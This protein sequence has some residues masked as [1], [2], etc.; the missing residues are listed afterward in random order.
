MTVRQDNAVLLSG[1]TNTNDFLRAC[2]E[3]ITDE[4]QTVKAVSANFSGIPL[5]TSSH[6]IGIRCVIGIANLRSP[7]K[8]CVASDIER[9]ARNLGRPQIN[10]DN[11]GQEGIR[12]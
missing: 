2:T 12:Y 7:R 10:A 1:D 6:T 5:R 11:D 8:Q 3:L 4:L 9:Q